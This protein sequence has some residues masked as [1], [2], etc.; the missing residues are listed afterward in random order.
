LNEEERARKGLGQAR[1]VSHWAKPLADSAKADLFMTYLGTNKDKIASAVFRKNFA[2]G[3][4]S[5]FVKGLKSGSP[6]DIEEQFNDILIRAAWSAGPKN[7]GFNI[8]YAREKANNPYIKYIEFRYPGHEVDRSTALD[9][10]NYYCHIVKTMSDPDYKREEYVKK[11][12]GLLNLTAES[13]LKITD[14][15]RKLMKPGMIVYVNADYFYYE[16]GRSTSV[17]VKKS[18]LQY[19][20]QPEMIWNWLMSIQN[21]TFLSP[22][23][24]SASL[25]NSYYMPAKIV[26]VDYDE[27]SDDLGKVEVLL[28]MPTSGNEQTLKI[29]KVSIPMIKFLSMFVGFGINKGLQ[30]KARTSPTKDSNQIAS[31]A[32]GSEMNVFALRDSWNKIESFFKD[33]NNKV[34]IEPDYEGYKPK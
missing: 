13:Q 34:V 3:M 1:K 30:I 12:I 17:L 6:S 11:F 7:I 33:H 4:A 29:E 31:N 2:N 23:S 19:I 15:I 9:L 27:E 16:A 21:K 22:R 5:D 26:K 24:L 10:T 28:V 32:T 18:G 20:F 8:N 14:N 25:A